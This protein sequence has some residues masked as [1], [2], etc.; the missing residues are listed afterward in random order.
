MS[1]WKPVLE[2]FSG[3]NLR[4]VIPQDS[5]SVQIPD[6]FSFL[7]EYTAPS[8]LMVIAHLLSSK[9]S[10]RDS[11]LTVIMS[12]A[13]NFQETSSPILLFC[14]TFRTIYS[15]LKLNDHHHRSHHP[16]DVLEETFIRLFHSLSRDPNCLLISLDCVSHTKFWVFQAFLSFFTKSLWKESLCDSLSSWKILL[17]LSRRLSFR[18]K[19]V[20]KVFPFCVVLTSSWSFFEVFRNHFSLSCTFSL[21]CCQIRT[22]RRGSSLLFS[23]FAQR[24]RM[25]RESYLDEIKKSN[26]ELR[27]QKSWKYCL[28]YLR[29]CSSSLLNNSCSVKHSLEYISFCEFFTEPYYCLCYPFNL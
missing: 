21:S 19:K 2:V 8:S 5:S 23:E 7:S 9:L 29:R 14:R 11:T 13:W 22:T 10:S 4:E 15:C 18:K 3:D 16:I 26:C 25:R 27:R 28:R 12:F 24:R 20:S 6:D 1:S 17:L